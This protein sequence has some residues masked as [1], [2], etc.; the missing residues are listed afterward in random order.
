MT[1]EPDHL[2][3]HRV[4]RLFH[5][6]RRLRVGLF[7]G[8]FNP[9]H[10]GHLHLAD[11]ARRQLRL[12]EIWWLVSPQNPLKPIDGMA[13]LRTRL[14]GARHLVAGRRHIRV[15]AP[16]VEFGMALTVNTLREL[17]R[18]CPQHRFCWLMGADNLVGFAGWKRHDVIARTMPIA[19][20]DRPGYSYAALSTGRKLLH[21]RMPPRRFA[22]AALRGGRNL[23][24]WCF[25]A[26]RRHHA[27]ATALR[28]QGRK[29]GHEDPRQGAFV[30][31][32]N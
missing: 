6:A 32:H 3:R 1:A 10:E 7:G 5:D 25:I 21:S 23:P 24:N 4:P 15:I 8:S 9:A 30:E 19:V 31:S 28:R 17:R 18:R 12:D 13:P 20:I 16:E 14:D 2:R 27:S 29:D 26:G 11:T 22:A